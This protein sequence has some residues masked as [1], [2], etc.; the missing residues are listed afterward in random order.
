MTA[1]VSQLIEEYEKQHLHKEGGLGSNPF[2]GMA[3]NEW[4][5]LASKKPVPKKLFSELWVEGELCVLFAPTNVGKSILAVQV[6]DQI[7]RG[8]SRGPF[9]VQTAA[10]PVVYLD[11]ELSDRQFAKRYCETEGGFYTNP[12]PF[13]PNFYRYEA[14]AVEDMPEGASL[15]DYYIRWIE[16]ELKAKNARVLIIDNLTWINTRLEKS[17][18]AGPFMQMLNRLKKQYELSI[19]LISHTPKRD[20]SREIGMND[21][22]GSSQVGNFLDS[23]FALN[24]SRK[25]PGL[26]YIK[27]VKVRD[28]EH[29]YNAENVI[30]CMLEKD[31]NCLGYR[32]MNFCNEKEHLH[33]VS[34]EATGRRNALIMGLKAE[35]LSLR[36]IASQIGCS[37]STV[38]RVLERTPITEP[39]DGPMLPDDD[40]GELPF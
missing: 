15:T 9:I 8:Q 37:Y 20:S 17:S 35:G 6:A 13:S 27:Q 5:E 22:Q 14:R 39:L 11:F 30:T 3:A 12:Y 33:T 10:Q 32:F 7:A 29:I 40:D 4:L 18:D 19:L 38:K 23:C 25:D 36:A 16:A 2:I 24:R 1:K 21:L 28:G 31:G 34:D 26:R